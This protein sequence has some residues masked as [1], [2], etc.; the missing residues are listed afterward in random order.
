M[1][2]IIYVGAILIG[3]L[4][5]GIF[6]Y[7]RF[8]HYRN[9]AEAS[10]RDI[11]TQLKLRWDLIP[12][13]VEVVRGYASHERGVLETVTEARALS[14]GA[15]NPF[16]QAQ[17]DDVLKRALF[18]L[19]AVVENYPQLQA[20]ESFLEMQRTLAEAEDAIQRSRKF[21]NAVVRE[22]NTT[23]TTFPKNMIAWIFRFGPRDYYALADELEHELPRI[24]L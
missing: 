17:A 3:I 20:N 18:S 10:W 1:A 22:L 4:I 13:V 11:D 12:N 16:D 8:V 19:F 9:L 2:A 7:N 15:D 5:W 14:L 6:T 21:Y 24:V 23:V